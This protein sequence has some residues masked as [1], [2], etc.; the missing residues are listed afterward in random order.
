MRI[1]LTACAAIMLLAFTAV[2]CHGQGWE[3]DWSIGPYAA[4]TPW[5][6]VTEGTTITLGSSADLS[7]V[8]SEVRYW[9]EDRERLW[10]YGVLMRKNV[11]LRSGEGEWIPAFMLELSLLDF[12][13]SVS[14]VNG[15]AGLLATY[16]LTDHIWI[17]AGGFLFIG[18]QWGSIG[19]VGT[20]SGDIYLDAPDGSRYMAGSRISASRWIAGTDFLAGLEIAL[21]DNIG[22]RGDGG[23]RFGWETRE[24]DYA[25]EDETGDSSSDLPASGFSEGPP[26]IDLSGPI[27]R[28]GLVYGF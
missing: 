7:P 13:T 4:S 5:L 28:I 1:R 12:D 11:F 9:P 24:W 16:A 25:V 10:T 8:P 15:G 17:S 26:E 2:L 3:E 6:V 22:I 14:S 20:A 18:Y 23:Y 19:E 21:S 27:M